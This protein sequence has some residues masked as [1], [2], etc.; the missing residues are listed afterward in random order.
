MGLAGLALAE[1]EATPEADAAADAWY[2]YY[3]HGLGYRRYYGGYYGGWR[4]YGGWGYGYYG[5]KREA[6]PAVLATTH[7]APAVAPLVHPYG[8]ALGYGYGL[9]HAPTVGYTV[10]HKATE[11]IPGAVTAVAGEPTV[12]HVGYAG[13]GGYGLWGRKK[14]EA[15]PAVVAVKHAAPTAVIPPPVPL[16]RGENFLA[17]AAPHLHTVEHKGTEIIPGAVAAGTTPVAYAAPYGYG[18]GYGY[19][20]HHPLLVAAPAAAEEAAVTDARK[21]READPEAE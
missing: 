2:G 10:E 9:H 4:G 13:Y 3:G 16:A 7:S 19:G 1:P 20:L 11:H 8:Y 12:V 17:P 21:K 15:D 6:D 18:Y 14:R 5:R